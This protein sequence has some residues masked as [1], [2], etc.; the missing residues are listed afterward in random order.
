MGQLSLYSPLPETAISSPHLKKMSS[1]NHDNEVFNKDI[2]KAIQELASRFIS[3]KQKISKNTADIRVIN[4]N[5]EGLEHLIKT[6]NDKVHAVNQRLS[7]Q[8]MKIEEAEYYSQ[9]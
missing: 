1:S 7:E 4:E 3:L 2:L 9:L 8:D 5:V 6:T